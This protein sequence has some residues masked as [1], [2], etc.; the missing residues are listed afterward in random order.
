MDLSAR[1]WRYPQSM[2]NLTQRNDPK[3]RPHSSWKVRSRQRRLLIGAHVCGGGGTG[4]RRRRQ[5]C[6]E[7]GGRESSGVAEV[8][9]AEGGRRET[10]KRSGVGGAIGGS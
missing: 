9:R 5:G 3:R 1:L 7:G 10:G 2:R 6:G 4:G 8:E